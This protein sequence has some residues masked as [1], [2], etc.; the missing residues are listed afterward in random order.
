M[1]VGLVGPYPP[2]RGGVSVHIE[3][4]E[5]FLN[6]QGVEVTIIRND[7][8]IVTKLRRFKWMMRFLTCNRVDILHIHWLKWDLRA[9]IILMAKMRKM[10]IVNTYHSIRE[11]LNELPAVQRFFASYVLKNSDYVIAVGQNEKDKLMEMFNCAGRMAVL[12]AFIPPQRV[13]AEIPGYIMEFIR[14]HTFIISANGSNMNFYQGHDLYGLDM[15]VELCGRLSTEI[16]VGF[17]YCLTRLTDKDYYEKIKARIAELKIENSFLIVLD[18]M[19]LWPILEKSHLFIR[20]TC[21]DS[22]GVSVAEALTLGIPSIASDVCKRPEGAVLFHSRDSEDLYHKVRE[23]H[24]NYE[25]YKAGAQKTELE[26]CAPAI[27]RIYQELVS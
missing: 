9:L 6:E 25:Q 15:L 1:K 27:L 11:D 8:S 10:K 16:N 26:N 18:N 20:P 13:N 3:R 7:R 14:S 12:P 2:P 5:E 19:E 17:I 23:I 22:Y 24:T 21:T 4:L